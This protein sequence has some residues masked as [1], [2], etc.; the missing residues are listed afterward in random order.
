MEK[1]VTTVPS[2]SLAGPA[3]E[4]IKPTD[5]GPPEVFTNSQWGT[6]SQSFL[7][8]ALRKP[9][10]HLKQVG[11]R[12]HRGPSEVWELAENSGQGRSII[13]TGLCLWNEGTFLALVLC[14]QALLHGW[15]V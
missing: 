1:A 12:A 15:E 8:E 10:F 13:S 7:G 6:V 4:S 11:H 3:Q 2:G 9:F 5:T 14:A